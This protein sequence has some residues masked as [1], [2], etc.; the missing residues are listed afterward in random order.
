MNIHGI[1]H[2]YRPITKNEITFFNISGKETCYSIIAFV[3]HDNLHLFPKVHS[4]ISFYTTPKN[5]HNCGCLHTYVHNFA[6]IFKIVLFKMHIL[7][8]KHSGICVCII[9]Y[10]RVPLPW[11]CNCCA[12]DVW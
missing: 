1:I 5:Y 2:T 8:N 6:N 4:Q 7:I 11:R 10:F 9:K 12:F 3:Y